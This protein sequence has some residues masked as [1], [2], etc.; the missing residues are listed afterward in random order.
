MGSIV[1]SAVGIQPSRIPEIYSRVATARKLLE[2]VNRTQNV[3]LAIGH[4]LAFYREILRGIK[5]FSEGRPRWI[6]TPIEP[7]PRAIRTRRVEELD[8]IIAHIF[9]EGLG[10]ALER[11]GK[12]VVNVSGVLPGLPFPRVIVDHQAVGRRAAEHLLDRGLLR[13]GFVGYDTHEF[14][15]ERERGFRAEIESRGGRLS[16]HRAP[17]RTERDLGGHWRV[18]PRLE[19]W[20]SK[21]ETPVGILASHDLQGVQLSEACRRLGLG[22][23]HQVAI[24]GVDD[25]DLLCA[26]A[27]PA[28]SSVI[29]PAQRIGYEAAQLLDELLCEGAPGRPPRTVLLP[30]LGLAVRPSSDLVAIEDE[31]VAAAVRF[32]RDHAFEPIQVG[33]VAGAVSVS[34]R[35]LER[36]FRARLGRGLWEEIRRVRM[37]RARELLASSDL[38]IAQIAAR[39]GFGESKQLATVFRQETGMSPTEYRQKHRAV[40]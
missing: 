13:F 12:P 20:L 2:M 25:D 4:D 17:A 30:P 36:R 3:G 14:S 7:E 22:V 24:V 29:L 27:R 9:T 21:L 10:R 15:V 31:D 35:S 28:L 18:D 39:A 33:D 5:A 38:A 26:M 6:F 32:I 16:I 11:S 8:G 23:P 34:R 40:P 37:V 1:G 19:R